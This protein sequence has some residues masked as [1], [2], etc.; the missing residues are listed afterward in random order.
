MGEAHPKA[1]CQTIVESYRRGTVGGMRRDGMQKIPGHGEWE[2]PIHLS[3]C[4]ALKKWK[5]E[6][7]GTMT[8]A[9]PSRWPVPDRWASFINLHGHS[10]GSPFHPSSSSAAVGLSADSVTAPVAAV[11]P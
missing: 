9:T 5:R 6:G 2:S 11:Q 3:G 1:N 10:M 4:G 7:R 8:G